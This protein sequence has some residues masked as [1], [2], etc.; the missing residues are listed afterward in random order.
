[1]EDP[2]V[3]AED[4]EFS[5]RTPERFRWKFVTAIVIEKLKS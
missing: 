3:K 4:V 2:K 1:M 5:G